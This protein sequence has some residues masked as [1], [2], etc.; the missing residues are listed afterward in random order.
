MGR[1]STI[2]EEHNCAQLYQ[3]STLAG[4]VKNPIWLAEKV[5]ENSP[6]SL[7]VSAGAERF[8]VS[9]GID[10]V[11]NESL[12]SEQAR[13]AWEFHCKNHHLVTNETG[14]DTVGAV[15]M[16]WRGHVAA[17]TSTGGLNG[18]AKGRVGDSP[19]AGAG[20]FAD[21]AIGTFSILKYAEHVLRT[22]FVL[23]TLATT[24]LDLRP[25]KA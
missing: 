24:L 9:Q 22:L 13:K 14:H 23:T 20:L 12:I 4:R 17:A 8:A 5:L 25:I 21:N 1:S 19:I 11:S 10:L 6:H 7:L 15:V 16:D 18:K 2:E 3:L